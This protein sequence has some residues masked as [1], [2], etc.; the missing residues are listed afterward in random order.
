[1][2][3]PTAFPSANYCHEFF[4]YPDKDETEMSFATTAISS[5]VPTTV[6]DDV[7]RPLPYADERAV[8]SCVVAQHPSGTRHSHVMHPVP[9][10]CCV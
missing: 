2:S 7:C 6:R 9:D 8:P 5:A 1:M 10:K 3:D 4:D